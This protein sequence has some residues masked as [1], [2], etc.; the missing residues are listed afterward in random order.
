M[1]KV[2]LDVLL[3]DRGL[4][5]SREKAT[6]V[7]MAGQVFLNGVRVAKPGT[8]IPEDAEPEI[9][10]STLAYVSRGGLKLLYYDLS[11]VVVLVY[12]RKINYKN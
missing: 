4:C 1:A 10:G 7:I 9:R 8:M 5:P 2:R 3:T 11:L 12:L 6:A